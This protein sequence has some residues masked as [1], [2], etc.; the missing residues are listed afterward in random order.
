MTHD[1]GRQECENWFS[2]VLPK[3]D[4]NIRLVKTWYTPQ[5]GNP[6]ISKNISPIASTAASIHQ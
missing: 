4:E 5:N 2:K 1:K 6:P 3:F